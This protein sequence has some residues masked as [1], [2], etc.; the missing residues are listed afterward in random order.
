MLKFVG[1]GDSPAKG[2]WVPA[3]DRAA[4]F[5]RSNRTQ[6]KLTINE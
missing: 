1:F 6:A 5:R 3:N 4:L 2:D